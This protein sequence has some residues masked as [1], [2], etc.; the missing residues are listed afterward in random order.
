M[1][2]LQTG[3]PVAVVVLYKTAIE[4]SVTVQSLMA[5]RA[6]TSLPVHV[7][8]VDNSA[9][10]GAA[11]AVVAQGVTYLPALGNLGLSNAY[12]RALEF[13]ERAGFDWLITLDQ[14]TALPSIFLREL[15]GVLAEVGPRLEIGAIVPQIVA[16][17]QLVSPYDFEWGARARYLPRGYVGVPDTRVFAFNSAAIVRVEAVR[18][19][20]GYSPYYWLDCSDAYL[21]DALWR[22]GKRVYVAGNLCVGHDFSMLDMAKSVSPWRY[23]HIQWAEAAFWDSRMNWL[24]GV[25]RTVALARR[26]AK[27]VSKRETGELQEI[28]VRS[29]RDRLLQ[30]KT[31]RRQM[32][33]RGVEAYLGDA[34]V[35]TAL[36]ARPAKV[37]VCMAAYNGGRYVDLQLRSI[38][39]QLRPWDEVVIVDD[40]SKDD[41][42]ARIESMGD[43]RIRLIVHT[44][45]KGVVG[46]FEE[47]LRSATGDFLF[48]SDDDD[49]WAPNKVERMLAAFEADPLVTIVTSRVAIIDENGDPKPG[50]RFDRGSRFFAGFWQ[51]V[52]KNN[53]QGSAMALRASLLERV[54]PFPARPAFLHDVWI[55]TR[56]DATGGKSIFLDED[57][58]LYRR[59][60]GNFS[61]Y[62]SLKKQLT[63]RLALLWAHLRVCLGPS[64]Q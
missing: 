35:K 31:Y 24:A 64:A 57:L 22:Y 42:V 28:T 25:Q 38:L 34:L 26:L 10:E 61:K 8:I 41:T 44:K 51:N 33:E 30:S 4:D 23:R 54:L 37:S 17:G 7:L 2:E 62:L 14:D 59:H 47:A 48:L 58:L 9:V 52:W 18:Q 32:F 60:P 39:D 53:Y 6:E 40:C 45:N 3:R 43:P 21:F 36:K 27:H 20:G 46:T 55:G 49:I 50:G 56:S 19:V 29:L 12:N 63:T 5:A 13:A 1:G 16:G 11:E 15:E